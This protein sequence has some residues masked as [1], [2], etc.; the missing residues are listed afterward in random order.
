MQIYTFLV[1]IKVAGVDEKDAKRSLEEALRSDGYDNSKIYNKTE[2][3]ETFSPGGKVEG[4]YW[5][6][7]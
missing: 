5:R 6:R 2:G 4:T 3:I 1:E 7:K